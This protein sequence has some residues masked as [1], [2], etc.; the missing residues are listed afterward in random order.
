MGL[1]RFWGVF[2]FL[3]LLMTGFNILSHGSTDLYYTY[4][5][6]DRHI[7]VHTASEIGI[8]YSIGA[9]LGGIAFGALSERWG[10]KRAIITAALLTLPAVPL[11]AFG[12]SA[13]LLAVGSVLVLFTV[14]GAWGVV[15]AYLNELAPAPVRAVFPGL[16]YQLGNLL[17]SRVNV[18]QAKAAVHT[19]SLAPVLASSVA[20]GAVFLAI[21]ASFGRE[22]RG[23]ALR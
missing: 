12:R 14:Q 17:A 19:G 16:V 6:E 4:L 15:P 1:R 8:L 20:A 11:Y 7:P 13:A 10:R 5:V 9:I 21:V 2:L 22:S 23:A 18:L 3:I